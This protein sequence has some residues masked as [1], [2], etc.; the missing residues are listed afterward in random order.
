MKRKPG[1]EASKASVNYYKLNLGYTSTCVPLTDGRR[2]FLPSATRYSKSDADD[3]RVA[4]PHVRL[5]RHGRADA[6][7]DS[8]GRELRRHCPVEG[9]HDISFMGLQMDAGRK[10]PYPHKGRLNFVNNQVNPSTGTIAECG[11]ANPTPKNG[12]R[13][14]SPGMLVRASADGQ[15][16]ALAPPSSIR[17]RHGPGAE[18][19]L[20]RRFGGQDSISSRDDG[21]TAGR[22]PAA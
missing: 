5:L 16:Q 6:G 13:L 22:R 18:V 1:I 2:T 10:D 9:R 8:G 14:L 19:R 4:G 3:G 12:I 21:P 17:N 7:E 15:S 20:R 11:C